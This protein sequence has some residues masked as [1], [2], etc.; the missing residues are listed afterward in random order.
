VIA[1]SYTLEVDGAPA[2]PEL[3]AA[4]QQIDVEDHADM[5][6]MLRLQVAV[7][8][9]ADGSGWTVLDDQAFTRLSNVRMKVTVGSG[10]AIPLIDAYVMETR[11]TFSNQPGQS[12][13]TIVAMDP[14]VL[15]HLEEKVK[16]WP[17]MADSDV[18]AAIFSDAAYRLSPVV[19]ATKWKRD[20]NEQTLLQRSTDIQ[21]L[22]QLADRNGYECYV[23]LN[24]ASGEVEGHFHPP[25]LDQ[26][27]QG[28][29]TVN[30]GEATNVNAFG[31]R[32]DMLRPTT[33]SVTGLDVETGS[34][35]PAAIDS[36]AHTDLGSTPAVRQDRPRKVLLSQ[37]AMAQSGELQAYAQAVVD[38]SAW[39][40]SAEGELNAVAFGGVLRAKRPVMVRGAGREFS[41]TYYVEKVLHSFT[42][43][44]YTQR[45]TL[46]RNALGLT[47]QEKFTADDALQS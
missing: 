10:S 44:G 15:M 35:Q 45:F 27:P 2:A 18:A 4:I 19:D 39:A 29:L 26:P 21:F 28:V 46:R 31:A 24:P 11:A 5:A 40:I 42:G 12:M 41:G 30:M 38:R 47:G 32:Y 37:T 17:N 33:A 16:A 36:A 8:I 1:V 14:T 7:A 20:E 9:R 25:R 13:L 3:I 34:D 43:D 6:D 22:R 23:E